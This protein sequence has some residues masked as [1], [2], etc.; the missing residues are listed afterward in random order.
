[1]HSSPLIT[2]RRDSLLVIRLNRPD[3]LNALSG[4]MIEAMS[5]AFNSVADNADVVILTGTGERAFCA[6]TDFAEINDED[7]KREI[8]IRTQR[9]CDQI[10]DCAVPVIAA[11]NGVACGSGLELALACHIRVAS[12]NA[13]FDQRETKPG[14]TGDTGVI[15]RLTTELG[16][17]RAQEMMKTGTI[18]VEEALN[19]GLINRV[20]EPGALLPQSEML[21]AE[22][23]R[24][25]PLAIRA[26]LQ[27][28]TRGLK[29][30]FAEG[31]ELEAE[32][33]ASLFGTDDMREG[34]RAFLEKRAPL[35]KGT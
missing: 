3:K 25:A 22:I 35:F 4:E 6:G 30:P 12:W 13:Q 31:L 21:A 15:Q 19:A 10:E 5:K 33:F 32:L 11:I 8:M 14:P 23:A 9:V 1:M 26:C 7:A 27:A 28:V 18:S 20:T 24:F 16:Q 29:L 17:E 34:T 2:E